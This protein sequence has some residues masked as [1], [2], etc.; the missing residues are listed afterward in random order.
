[1]LMMVVLPAP[2]G[3]SRPNSSPDGTPKETPSTAV[4]SSTPFA[5]LLEAM[6]KLGLPRLLTAQLG[7]LYRYIFVLIDQAM[8]LRR[9]RD[10]RS[11]RLA[12]VGR[13]LSAA[14]NVIGHLFLRT[15]DRSDRIQTAMAARGYRG[16]PHG[17]IR[18]RLRGADGLFALVSACYLVACRW[19]YP[20]LVHRS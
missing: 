11:A 19:A 10:F 1:M 12:P 7:L 14:G 2:F 4:T 13:R 18:L 15:L 6:R 5:L 3:P 8:R 20:L 9:G 16:E 17:L